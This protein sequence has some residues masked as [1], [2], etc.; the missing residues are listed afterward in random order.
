MPRKIR[1]L[2]HDL[3]KAGFEFKPGKGSH[4]KFI[5]P[6]GQSVVLSGNLG[7]DAKR[8]QEKEVI[9]KIKESKLDD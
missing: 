3:Q 2:I 7:D 1:Q 6:R 4:R 5:H 9:E 8:Y